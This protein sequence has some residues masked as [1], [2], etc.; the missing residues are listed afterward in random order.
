VMACT[1]QICANWKDDRV[2]VFGDAQAAL[3]W[4]ESK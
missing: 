2:A 3:E 1:Y 4:I